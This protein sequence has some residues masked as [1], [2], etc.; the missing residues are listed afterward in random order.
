GG[1]RGGGGGGG[2]GVLG[3]GRHGPGVVEG[4][5]GAEPDPEVRHEPERR[6]VADDP[7]ERCGDADGAALVAAE[8]DVHLA[9]GHRRAGARR[10]SAGHVLVVVRIQGAAVV[11]EGAAGAKAATPPVHHVL[12]R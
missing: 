1:G 12:A 11:A 7:A 6:L 10:R 9:G 8:R 3:G 2:R 5:V 4:L